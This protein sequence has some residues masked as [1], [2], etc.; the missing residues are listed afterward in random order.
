MKG[1]VHQRGKNT[2]LIGVDLG[3]DAGGKRKRVWKTLHGPKKDAQRELTRILHELDTGA[4]LERWLTD[5][6]KSNTAPRT[7]EGYEDILQKHL[8]P[9]LGQIPLKKLKPLDIQGYY[10]RALESGRLRVRRALQETREGG[11]IL[12]E[13]KSATSRRTVTLPPLT[14]E[15]LKRHREEQLLQKLA[16]GPV[17]QDTGFVFTMPVAAAPSAPSTSPSRSSGWCAATGCR[18]CASTISGTRTPPT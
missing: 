7:Y 17:W 4:Y 16:L 1:T 14:V 5:Y 2:W 8:I 10:T 9:A 11:L 13:P 3:K 18:R 12:K 6:A 15:V